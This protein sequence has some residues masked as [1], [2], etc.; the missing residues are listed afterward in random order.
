MENETIIME[1]DLTPELR[2]SYE[3]IAR[4]CVRGVR[5]CATDD[6]YCEVIDRI[7][8]ALAFASGNIK[9]AN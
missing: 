6:Q 2:I 1:P 5:G 3:S 7:V 8:E 4:R 9:R